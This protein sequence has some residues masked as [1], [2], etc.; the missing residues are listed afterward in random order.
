MTAPAEI[1]ADVDAVLD[2]LDRL[3]TRQA[4]ALAG[5]DD[6]GLLATLGEKQ[7]VLDAVDLPTLVRSAGLDRAA[8]L[9]A[10]IESLIRADGEALTSAVARRDELAGELGSLSSAHAARGAYGGS[11]EPSPRSRLNVAG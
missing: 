7:R 11:A 4:A 8:A 10:R 1:E 5:G 6:E 3:A 9:K 2:Q